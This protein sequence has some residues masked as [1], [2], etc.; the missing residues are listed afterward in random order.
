[1]AHL[2]AVNHSVAELRNVIGCLASV[3]VRNVLA[4]RGDPPGDPNGPWVPH[5]EGFALRRRARRADQGVRRLLRRRRRV[6]RAA[7]ALARRGDRHPALRREVPGRRRLRHHPD[8]LLPRGLPP[9]PGPGRRHGCD[10]PIIPGI[11]PVT[12]LRVVERS[13]ELSGCK[14]PVGLL[15]QLRAA[16]ARGDAATVCAI[17]VDYAARL[18]ARLLDEGVP[19]LHFITLNASRATM[20]IYQLLGLGGPGRRRARVQ[21]QRRAHHRVGRLAAG[22]P[23]VR[24][25]VG[26]PEPAVEPP[27]AGRRVGGGEHRGALGTVGG[28]RQQQRAADSV[29]LPGA[30]ARAA[31]RSR[32]SRQ[33]MRAAPSRRVPRPSTPAP[34]ARGERGGH[35]VVPPLPVL[36][37]ES[38]G[39]ARRA[40]RRRARSARGS[41][42]SPRAAP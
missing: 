1:M 2:T 6:P 36:P 34:R 28:D 23:E 4:L 5:P 32:R 25:Q 17:G 30:A 13:I 14:V 10:V 39:E 7:P 33:A 15:D 8:V 11:M 40:A 22:E 12:S 31:R 19:G 16:D 3:G 35:H 42:G 29:A 21:R 41:R 38:V 9:A 37:V 24:Q 20:E 26:E 18:C 27:G